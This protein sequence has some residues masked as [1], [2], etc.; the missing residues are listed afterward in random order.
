[1]ETVKV[2]FKFKVGEMVYDRFGKRGIVT[3]RAFTS[4]DYEQYYI[5]YNVHF[6]DDAMVLPEICLSTEKTYSI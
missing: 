2:Q 4:Y 5:D 3:S 6:E 1:M